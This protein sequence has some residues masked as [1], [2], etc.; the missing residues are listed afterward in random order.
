MTGPD[1]GASIRARLLNK[2]KRAG[3]DF[4]LMLTR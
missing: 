1:V 4:N 2:A 3:A